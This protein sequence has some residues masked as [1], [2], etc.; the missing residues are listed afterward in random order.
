M[1][2]LIKKLYQT[3][4]SFEV[5]RLMKHSFVYG[6]GD[7]VQRSL[8][9]ILLPIY[10]RYLTPTDYGIISLLAILNMI[11]GTIT[12]CGLTN[13]ISR[14]FYYTD[15]ENTSL[16]KVVCCQYHQHQCNRQKL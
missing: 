4:E 15:Q 13:G 2:K 9:I 5:L 7:I 6:I 14:Y 11:V 10:T 16:S 3:F 8:S 12:M 1:I